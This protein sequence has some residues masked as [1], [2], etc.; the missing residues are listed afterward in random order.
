MT[1]AS[2]GPEID[3]VREFAE[4]NYRIAV[5]LFGGSV[6][7]VQDL[8]DLYGV[9]TGI[10]VKTEVAARDEVVTVLNFVLGSRYHLTVA[11]LAALRGHLTDSFRSLRMAIERRESTTSLEPPTDSAA[12]AVDPKNSESQREEKL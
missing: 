11:A 12:W 7:L 6:S 10:A 8:V 1:A 3:V 2:G 5:N 4:E 9:L